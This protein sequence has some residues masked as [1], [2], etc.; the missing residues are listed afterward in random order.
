MAL[1]CFTAASSVGGSQRNVVDAGDGRT[2][3][4]TCAFALHGRLWT[5]ERPAAMVSTVERLVG[6]EYFVALHY[7]GRFDVEGGL[8]SN[9]RYVDGLCGR[10]LLAHSVRYGK[11]HL[12]AAAFGIR[13]GDAR[14]VRRGGRSSL[15]RPMVAI[16]VLHLGRHES[17]AVARGYVR[18]A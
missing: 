1:R 3:T 5:N 18:F 13:H 14:L 8:G 2:E 11:L 16:A 15:Q 4:D 9:G 10:S 12:I 17:D 7:Y 6:Q